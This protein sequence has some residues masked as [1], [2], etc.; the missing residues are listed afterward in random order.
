[1]PA[2]DRL[3]NQQQVE[4][5]I[6]AFASSNGLFSRHGAKCASVA[7]LN[8]VPSKVRN[9]RDQAAR[10]EAGEKRHPGTGK[11]SV[12]TAM[13][14][15]ASWLN[16]ELVGFQLPTLLHSFIEDLLTPSHCCRRSWTQC[17]QTAG[18]LLPMLT[19]T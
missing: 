19:T 15:R 13:S 1:M 10:H 9:Q 2:A 14:R 17:K 3:V 7:L 5:A 18:T 8:H 11:A 6:A 16:Y 12:V 4:K